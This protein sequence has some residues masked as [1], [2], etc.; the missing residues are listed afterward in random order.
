MLFFGQTNT[1]GQGVVN[2]EEWESDLSA[3][4]W[5]DRKEEQEAIFCEVNRVCT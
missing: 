3:R 2:V 1:S 4:D 5:R